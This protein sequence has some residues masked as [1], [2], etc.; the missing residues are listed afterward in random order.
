MSNED[1]GARRHEN[2]L[3]PIESVLARYPE[4]TAGELGLLKSWFMRQASALEV[5]MLASNE[6]IAAQYAQ[7]RKDHLDRIDTRDVL[8]AVGWMLAA[9]GVIAAV[10]L[11]VAR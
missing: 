10:V 8:N 4:I 6:R 11:F 7:F 2:G 9:S 3:A 5:G 1:S